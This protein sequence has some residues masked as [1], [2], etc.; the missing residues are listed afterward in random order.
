[1]KRHHWKIVPPFQLK[2]ASEFHACH[3]LQDEEQIL[4]IGLAI[5]KVMF[6]I[7][8]RKQHQAVGPDLFPKGFVVHRLQP[9]HDIVDVFKFHSKTS[10]PD[11]STRSQIYTPTQWV[12]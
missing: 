11:C 3:R 9:F 8:A 4:F 12:A 6:T 7:N 2:D 1:M 10:L 5:G